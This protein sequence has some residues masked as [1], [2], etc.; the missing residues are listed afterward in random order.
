MTEFAIE[1]WDVARLV[2]YAK[3]AKKHPEDQVRRLANTIARFGWDQPIVVD[4][5]GVIIKGHGR[6]MAAL[7]LGLDKVPVLVRSDLTP[8]EADAL[9][10]ADNAVVGLDFDTRL[11]QEELARLMAE[12]DLSF[13]VDDIGLSAKEH[14]L[15]LR[16]IDV[17]EQSALIEDTTAEI[18][19]QKQEE[20]DHVSNA[21]REQIPLADA[22]GFKR[23]SREYARV[24]QRLMAEAESV[25]GKEG[26]DAFVEWLDR[27]VKD[28]VF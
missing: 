27:Q 15:L 18:E 5:D 6:R 4:A 10:I 3:N 16:Q 13:T 20:R 8:S 25:S 26:H 14:D 7:K 23:L 19:R 9:R 2:P 11:M 22:F 12:D 21:D 28:G 24:V 17:A 1:L